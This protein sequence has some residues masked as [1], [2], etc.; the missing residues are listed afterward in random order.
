MK[1]DT[2]LPPKGHALYQPY[3]WHTVHLYSFIF[4]GVTEKNL[5]IRFLIIH[6]FVRKNSFKMECGIF[7]HFCHFPCKIGTQNKKKS[8]SPLQNFINCIKPRAIGTLISNGKG[9]TCFVQQSIKLE[10]K[11]INHDI[12][13]VP[14]KISWV[15]STKQKKMGMNY[16]V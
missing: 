1:R 8:N 16:Q 6:N 7:C 13:I 4:V 15:E 3:I 9:V 12:L 10:Q 14:L 11:E 2:I 5:K